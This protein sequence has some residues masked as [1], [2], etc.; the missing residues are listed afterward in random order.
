MVPPS[1]SAGPAD[2]SVIRL[3][4]AFIDE[5][6][7]CERLRAA[8]PLLDGEIRGRLSAFSDERAAA[9]ALVSQLLLRA[10]LE[11]EGL[12]RGTYRVLRDGFGKPF[13]EG[14]P[15]HFNLSH[16]GRWCVCAVSPSIV[17]VDVQE[18]RTVSRAVAGR[19]YSDEEF[20]RLDALAGEEYEKEF[21]RIWSLK[22]SYIKC[23][24]KGLS[25]PLAS[26]SVPP[27]SA[28]PLR[29]EGIPAKS[30]DLEG[31][32]LALCGEGGF[33]DSAEELPPALC[34]TV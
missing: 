16:S 9:H 32:S 26:F 15:L 33:P 24:G 12:A 1:R 34:G 21:F 18:H 6:P 20:R 22:E 19:F 8:E 30:F 29:I 14:M 10:A 3:Y 11:R 31:Y 7:Y 25:H 27:S 17:G 23:I 13:I 4:S 2:G 28:G 5:R